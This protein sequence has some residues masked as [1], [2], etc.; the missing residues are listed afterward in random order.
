MTELND[1][2]LE[3]AKKLN[4]NAITD[5]TGFGLL[6]HMSEMIR[7]DSE[8]LQKYFLDNVPVI[9]FSKGIFSNNGVFSSGSLRNYDSISSDLGFEKDMLDRVKILSDAQTSGGLLISA[10]VR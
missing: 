2:A 6:G 9:R 5:V 8:F 1:R 3:F 7:D 10:P 4:A